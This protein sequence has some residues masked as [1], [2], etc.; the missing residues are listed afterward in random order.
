M[1]TRLFPRFTR[2]VRSRRLVYSTLAALAAIGCVGAVLAQA[3][4]YVPSAAS[5]ADMSAWITG[6]IQAS[7]AS[8]QSAIA[9]GTSSTQSSICVNSGT[10]TG[11]CSSCGCQEATDTQCA[12]C[13]PV[14]CN[15]F[16]DLMDKCIVVHLDGNVTVFGV[17]R[18]QCG[19]FLILK[20]EALTLTVSIQKILYIENY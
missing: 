6:Q 17:L 1:K 20:S 18:K 5:S 16:D 2:P 9:T 15:P 19:G 3:D 7:Q 13:A 11:G 12:P 8:I 10:C 14:P 4:L